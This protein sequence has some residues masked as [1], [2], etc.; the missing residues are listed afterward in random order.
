MP[1][2]WKR[3]S[4]DEIRRVLGDAVPPI[5]SPRAL[6]G[7][8]RLS[9]KTIYEWKAKGRLD[10]AYRKRGRHCLIWRDR[11]LPSDAETS[12]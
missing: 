6:A 5:L 10:G 2:N 8:L 9:V 12:P 3:L 1:K 4:K 7:L 11:A